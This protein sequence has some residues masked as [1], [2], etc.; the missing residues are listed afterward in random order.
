MNTSTIERTVRHIFLA[1]VVTT[2]AI[3]PLA[4]NADVVR[5]YDVDDYVQ[6]GLVLHF[7][8]IRN[9]G[10][11][12]PHVMAGT[13]WVNLADPDNSATIQ[14]WDPTNEPDLTG[15]W[16]DTGYHF[17]KA[18]TNEFAVIDT[19]IDIGTN[20]TIQLA[21]T[22]KASDQT[23]GS[24]PYRYPSYFNNYDG[25]N[26]NGIWT[27]KRGAKLYGSFDSYLDENFSSGSNL[28]NKR[29]FQDSWQGKYITKMLAQDGRA[30]CFQGDT[31]PDPGIGT[32]TKAPGAQRYTFSGTLKAKKKTPV[33]GEYHSVRVY[34]RVLS[35]AE[36]RQNRIVDEARYRNEATKGKLPN[37]IVVGA[38]GTGANVKYLVMGSETFSAPETIVTVKGAFRRSG[39]VVETW[40]GTA[41]SG[42]VTNDSGSCVITADAGDAA[43]RVTWL[44]SD[45]LR[46]YDVDDYVQDGLVLHFDGIRNAGATADHETE[47]TTWKNLVAGLPDATIMTG[48]G[49]EL[50]G[51]WESNGFRL[52]PDDRT[53][54]QEYVCLDEAVDIGKTFA[55]QLV[56]DIDLSKQSTGSYTY[57]RYPSYFNTYD[58]SNATGMWTDNRSSQSTTLIGAL[59][60]YCA[61]YKRINIISWDGKYV[62]MMLSENAAQGW[63]FHAAPATLPEGTSCEI[64]KSPGAKKYTWGGAPNGTKIPVRGVYH[65]VRI[66]TNTLDAA[67]IQ[68]NRKIDD[69]RFRGECDVTIV[70]GAVGETGT[71]GTSSFAD[72]YY[73]MGGGESWTL[74]AESV[75]V[76]G[77]TY[78]PHL[79]VETWNGSEWV[80]SSTAWTDRYT[81]SKPV[82]ARVRLTWTWSVPQGLIIVFH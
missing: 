50:V 15:E 26:H 46:S 61:S 74:T 29:I 37:V 55:I 44:W 11:T 39:Y 81:L 6:D 1:A 59:D 28:S 70:N 13:R 62:T 22:I 79:L 25:N 51:Y 71:N 73:N 72:G 9:A 19:A 41:W 75:K 32:I 30:W 49:S 47:G 43:K 20:N 57:K 7:D 8:G 33:R 18:G 45:I 10:A 78:Q 82:S 53:D 3:F 34:A 52:N 42:A 12:T 64:T 16:T 68:L 67:Q 48:D 66:Y 21:T 17:N 27:E 69:A 63:H 24:D 2:G 40:D 58:G 36:I 31:P 60:N 5:I 14:S 23:N 65:A 38:D 56:T 80:R 35:A 4:T 77:K 54:L 76:D